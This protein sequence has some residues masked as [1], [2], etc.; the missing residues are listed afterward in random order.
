MVRGLTWKSWAQD[1]AGAQAALV[2][3]DRQDRFGSSDFL[4]EHAAAGA[5]EPFSAAP[6]VAESFDPGGLRDRQPLDQ[7]AEFCPRHAC[8]GR[9]GQRQG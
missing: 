1:V 6:L 4:E 2:E 5:W 9:V 7:C 8:Q 3:D